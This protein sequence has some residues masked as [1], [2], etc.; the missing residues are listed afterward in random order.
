MLYI[1]PPDLQKKLPQNWEFSEKEFK[2]SL[3]YYKIYFI[4]HRPGQVSSVAFLALG[5]WHNQ[6]LLLKDLHRNSLKIASDVNFLRQ[7]F[8]LIKHSQFEPKIISWDTGS[9]TGAVWPDD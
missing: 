5:A 4:K 6:P 1:F 7:Y 8:S 2:V 3:I 9:C